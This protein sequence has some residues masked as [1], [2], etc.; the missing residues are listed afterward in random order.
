MVEL[1]QTG[2]SI[3]ERWIEHQ[4]IPTNMQKFAFTALPFPAQLSRIHPLLKKALY[5]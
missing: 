4:H 2:Q 1:G 5:D 3:V